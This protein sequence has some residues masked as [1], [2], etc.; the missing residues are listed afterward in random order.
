MIACLYAATMLLMP[1][2]TLAQCQPIFTSLSEDITVDCGGEL[3]S[4]D[5]C[6]AISTCCD[7]PVE[8]NSLTSETGAL[9]SDCH[10]STAPGPGVDWAVW[11]PMIDAPSVAWN[12]LGD[13]HFQIYGDG[14]AHIWGTV[15]NA[16]NA[17]LQ[18]EVEMW[19]QN[20]V[21]WESWSALG[22]MYKN[23]LGFAGTNYLNW[24]YFELVAGFSRL[25]GV[26]AL[27][28]TLIERIPIRNWCK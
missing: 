28:G 27:E 14:T 15:A 9:L 24:Q 12:F 3:P 6:S 8:V 5:D 22:R 13:G 17:A 21:D 1:H 23:D 2:Q 16:G 4:L 20:G 11:L 7:G 25:T 26:G 18:L 19:L 10:L